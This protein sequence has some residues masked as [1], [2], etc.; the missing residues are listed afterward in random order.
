MTAPPAEGPDPVGPLPDTGTGVTFVQEFHARVDR[1]EELRATLT[2][3]VPIIRHAAGCRSC[4]LL[5]SE[6]EPLRFVVFAIWDSRKAQ[7]EAVHRLPTEALR[8]A[9]TLVAEVPRGGVWAERH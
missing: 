8:R 5:Q 1:G 2:S 9:M 4:Q 7:E 3:L 6:D